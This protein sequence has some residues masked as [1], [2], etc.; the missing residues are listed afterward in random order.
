MGGAGALAIGVALLG[1]KTLN[2]VAFQLTPGLSPVDG[3]AIHMSSSWV[4]LVAT[5]LKWPLSVTHCQSASMVAVTGGKT[6]VNRRLAAKM[7]LGFLLTAFATALL[8]A[9]LFGLAT[10]NMTWRTWAPTVCPVP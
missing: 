7:L 4:F 10:W 1:H 8:S 6:M 5:Y 2:A 3:F 9:A